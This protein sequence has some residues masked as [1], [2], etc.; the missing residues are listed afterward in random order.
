MPDPGVRNQPDGPAPRRPRETP[1]PAPDARNEARGRSFRARACGPAIA[2][3]IAGLTLAVFSPALRN[4]FVNWDD[5][6]NILWNEHFRG[7]DAAHLRWMFTTTH[8]GHYQP[9][10]WLTLALDYLLAQ[11]A[12]GNGLDPRS[13][14]LT[15][16]ILHALNA[17]LVFLLART[18]L[19][20]V[21]VSR[22]SSQAASFARAIASGPLCAAAVLAALLFAWHPLRVESVAWATERRDVLSSFFLL[23][24][25][26]VYV[27]APA[28][29]A[30]RR[31]RWLAGVLALFTLSLLSRALAVVLPAILLLLDWYPL[32]RF[33]V[34]ATAR[35]RAIGAALLEKIPF[36]VLAALA[37]AMAV[38]AQS[39][40]RAAYSLAEHGPLARVVQACYA[41]CFYIAKSLV[42]TA[43]SPIYE[44]VLPLDLGAPR[45]VT[46]AALVLACLAA[47]AWLAYHARARWLVAAATGY[48]LLVLPVAGLVQSGKQEV[49]DRYSYLPGIVLGLVLAAGALRIW[50]ASAAPRVLKAAVA[51]AS[52]AAVLTLAALTWRQCGVWRNTATLWAHG[53]AIQPHSSIAQTE[54]GCALLAQGRSEDALTHLTRA[55]EIWPGNALAHQRSWQALAALGR[56][57]ELV[58]AVRRAIDALPGFAEA[59]YELGCHLSAAGQH[60]DAIAA[61]RQ[62][63]LHQPAHSAA[64]TNLAN[65]LGRRGAAAEALEHYRAA[66][67]H[68]PQNIYA[69][70]GLAKLHQSQGR[71]DEA[72]DALRQALRLAPDD[73]F[74][75]RYWQ[76]WTGQPPDATTRD[77]P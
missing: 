47:L 36:I 1:T 13:Y 46:A 37:A 24:A 38:F 21:A 76:E 77:A 58:A 73:P 49:A 63:L 53:V 70:R 9:L 30:R 26:L 34:P 2:L 15:N 57:A 22:R 7:L 52:A 62:A 65:L 55:T 19:A 12:F 42:P 4:D 8:A 3:A 32:G 11:A 16:C 50:S 54:H 71:S 25:V 45:Y 59:H 44:L 14:H 33:D 56:R 31:W 61:Y 29:P 41:L 67:A 75:L 68:D 20:A 17:A 18:I 10:S 48:L 23:L 66:L 28:G 27:R 72:L 43:L 60:D 51:L 74:A 35:R 64:H 39:A 6:D 40:M 5:A 69:W